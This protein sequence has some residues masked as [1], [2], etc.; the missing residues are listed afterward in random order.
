MWDLGKCTDSLCAPPG[1]SEHQLGL[2][3]DLFDATTEEEYYKNP[4]YVAYVGWL[5]RYAH[6][7]GWTQSY[8]K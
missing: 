2:A 3:V 6:L 5:K 1:H 4:K 7:Y 8:Q